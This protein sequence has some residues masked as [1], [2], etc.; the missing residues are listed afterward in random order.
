MMTVV[1][2]VVMTMTVPVPVI[3]AV[4][5]IV[6]LSRADADALDVMVMAL[7]GQADLGLEAEDTI[8]VFAQLAVHVVLARTDLLDPLGEGVEHERM[9]V[10][11][12]RLDELN[13]GMAFGDQVR[14]RVDALD[15]DPGKA[16]PKTYAEIGYAN[17]NRMATEAGL[18]P[19]VLSNGP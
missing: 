5:V 17:L 1:V 11:V 16:D 6:V 15:Q 8:A 4:P 13:L 3:V 9:V 14:V 18:I 7:L 12:G 2:V 10:E 19:K